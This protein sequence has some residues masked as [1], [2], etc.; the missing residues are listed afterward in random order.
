MRAP[1]ITKR[2]QSL[3]NNGTGDMRIFLNPFGD[4]ALERIQLTRARTLSGRL[5]RRFQIL[6]D[7]APTQLEVALDF[8]NGPMLGPV[9]AVQLVDLVGG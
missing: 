8:A 3:F 4:V 5:R 9:K 6:L 2:L 1:A 7:G